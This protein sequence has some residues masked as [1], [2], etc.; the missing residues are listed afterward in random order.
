MTVSVTWAELQSLSPGIRLHGWI[1][2][3]T[4]L[5]LVLVGLLDFVLLV[6]V[7]ALAVARNEFASADCVRILA[8]SGSD[9][10]SQLAA[11]CATSSAEPSA[12]PQPLDAR[13][14]TR[15][16]ALTRKRT[17]RCGSACAR[18][19][20]RYRS[21]SRSRTLGGF[22]RTR[23]R[24]GSAGGGGCD[25][26]MRIASDHSV[27]CSLRIVRRV[28][29]LCS[30]VHAACRLSQPPIVPRIMAITLV[31]NI[32]AWIASAFFFAIHVVYGC[33]A[34]CG[35]QARSCAHT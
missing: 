11:V 20:R 25:G 12:V 13:R 34:H 2:G 9:A 19:R 14:P 33:V 30:V 4:R 22:R 18:T 10:L 3:Y 1:D 5:A 23:A 35:T 6:T 26:P 7:I 31:I 8:I 32:F 16:R 27:R 21:R 24:V 29:R 28:K 15:A 17:R